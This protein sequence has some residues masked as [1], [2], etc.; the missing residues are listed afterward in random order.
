MSFGYSVSDVFLLGQLAWNATQNARKACGE[1]G[2]LTR[3]VS[4]LHVVLRRLEQELKKPESPINTSTPG[5]TCREEL[6]VI[7]V[8]CWKVLRVLDKILEKYN[9][10]SEK[11][12]SGRKLWQRIKFGNGEMADLGDS[13]SKIILYTSS[14]T[15]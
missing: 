3:E 15:F 5:D 1:H 11:E 9:A 4:A 8:D 7:M 6:Q 14:I 10:L 2:G 12:R 13:R